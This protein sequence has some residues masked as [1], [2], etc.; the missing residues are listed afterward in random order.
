MLNWEPTLTCKRSLNT[1]KQKNNTSKERIQ[2]MLHKTTLHE[3]RSRKATCIKTKR[4][5]LNLDVCKTKT[6]TRTNERNTETQ[7]LSANTN[8]KDRQQ[9]VHASMQTCKRRT[10][11][12]L[13]QCVHKGTKALAQNRTHY[14]QPQVDQKSQLKN[15]WWSFA[16]PPAQSDRCSSALFCSQGVMHILLVSFD[17][18]RRNDFSAIW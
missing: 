13:P 15:I 18:G 12:F 7:R 8:H 9:A 10:T 1:T 5:R 3:P 16:P 14:Q 11:P 6:T 17:F 2:C 4:K